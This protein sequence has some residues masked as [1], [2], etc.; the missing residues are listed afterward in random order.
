MFYFGGTFPHDPFWGFSGFS[1]DQNAQIK[2]GS[3]VCRVRPGVSET[4]GVSSLQIDTHVTSFFQA[5]R[6]SFLSSFSQDLH[7]RRPLMATIA[8]AA[9]ADFDTYVFQLR[10]WSMFFRSGTQ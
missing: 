9:A 4:L 3:W 1:A 6:C 2:F 5:K 10:P 7:P 8:V